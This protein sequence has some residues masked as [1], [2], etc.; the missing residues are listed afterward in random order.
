MTGYTVNNRGRYK[1]DFC[2]HS[3]YKTMSGVLTHVQGNHELELANATAEALRAQLDRERS[4]P[5]KVEIRERERVVYK[6]KPEP[7]YSYTNVFCT[8]CKW[9]FNA[10][11]PNG[12]SVENTRH[13]HCG[14]VTLFPVTRCD[15]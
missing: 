7:K 13:S 5:P 6:D 11:I 9:V 8:T 3:T 12:Y 14:N 15:I 1:C 10:G 4:K 2:D